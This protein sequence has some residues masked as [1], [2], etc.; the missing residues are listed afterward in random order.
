MPISIVKALRVFGD[1]K[2]I[3]PTLSSVDHETR[4][5]EFL[6]HALHLKMWFAKAVGRFKALLTTKG[7]TMAKICDKRINERER[8][9]DLLDLALKGTE[10][11]LQ[12][13]DVHNFVLALAEC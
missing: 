4:E 8:E 9:E 6:R 10:I 3:V 11:A 2:V 12:T 7:V 1:C 13:A 5:E